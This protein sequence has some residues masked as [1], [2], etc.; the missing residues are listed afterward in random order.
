MMKN[1]ST[2]LWQ[3]QQPGKND[4]QNNNIEKNELSPRMKTMLEKGRAQARKRVIERGIAQFRVDPN[5]MEQLLQISEHRG[6][7]LGTMLR[8]WIKDRLRSEHN[9]TKQQN[10][11]EYRTL[12][13]E[14]RD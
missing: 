14:V 7:P 10:S 11:T 13:L 1:I 12:C 4:M 5:I 9:K 8:E 3:P 6:I 2:T